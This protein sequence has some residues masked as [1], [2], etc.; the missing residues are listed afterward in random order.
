MSIIG[1]QRVSSYGQNEERQLTDVDVDEMFTDKASGKDTNR[2]QLS[3]AIRYA[4][5][6]DV[7][8]VHSMDRLARNIVDLRGIVEELNAKGVAVRFVKENLVFNGE[9]SAMNNLLLNMLGAV[10]EFERSLIKERQREG[11]A[12][13]KAKGKYKGRKPSLTSAQVDEVVELKASGVSIAEIA[14]R[15]GV[16][17]PSIYR[18]LE[19]S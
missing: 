11:I 18:A 19:N 14:R 10:A 8:V 9:D 2:P 13:A 16:S 17:R 4:R 3:A 5:K 6:G 1:Y 7:F 15:Y 12:I